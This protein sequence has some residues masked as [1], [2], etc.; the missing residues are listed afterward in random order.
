MGF[1]RDV[2]TEYERQ[3]SERQGAIPV[4]DV[5]SD[6]EPRIV[7]EQEQDAWQRAAAT[8]RP[9]RRITPEG[10]WAILNLSNPFR[11]RRLRKDYKWAQ[12]VLA[13]SSLNPEDLRFIL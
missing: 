3:Q 11:A 5:T 9:M 12:K 10:M 1:W 4:H 2:Q 7:T 6:T 8:R 13:K